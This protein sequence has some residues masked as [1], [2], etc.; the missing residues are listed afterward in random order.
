MSEIVTPPEMAKELGVTGLQ[1]RN[2][3]RARASGGHPLL[4]GHVKGQRWE[5]SPADAETLMREFRGI[6]FS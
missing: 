3:L 5:F 2:W 4:A 6:A 1:L